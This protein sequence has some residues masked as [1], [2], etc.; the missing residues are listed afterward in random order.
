[1]TKPSLSSSLSESFPRSHGA[2]VGLPPSTLSL[3][4]RASELGTPASSWV[5]A[6]QAGGI[7]RAGPASVQISVLNTAIQVQ[8]VS[9]VSQRTVT[10]F[11]AT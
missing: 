6:P 5:G 2:R 3:C 7:K 9:L 1:M 8:I 11:L 10:S 4:L